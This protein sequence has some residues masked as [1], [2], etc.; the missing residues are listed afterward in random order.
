MGLSN[1]VH[2]TNVRVAR[3]PVG[4]WFRLEGSG[5][6]LERKG[7]Y[8]FTEIR[9]GLATF[10]AMA[11]IIS[12]NSTITSATGGTCVC[13]AEDMG[14]FCAT[15]VE[16]ALCTQEVKRD[17]VTATAAIAALST[18][19]MGLFANL[20]I[21]LAPGMGLNAYF[22]YTVVGVR[23]TGMVSYSTALTAVFVEGWVFLG[24]TL[25]GMR[26]WLARAL[27]KSIKLATGVGIGLY[28]ALIGLTYSAGIGL[29]QGAS[30]TPIELAGCIESE[31]D[32]VTGLCHS[33]AKMRSPT[34]WIGIFCGGILTVL[35]MMYRIKGA[36][37]I[38]ILLV[39]I[40]SWPRTTPVTYF[41]YTDLGT[42]QFD[43]FKQVVTFHPIKHT[44]SAQDWS[45]SGKGGQFGLAFITFLYVDIL[46]TTGTMYSMA[47]FAG[48]INEETQDFEGSAIAYMVDAISISIGSLLGS[49]PVTAFVESGAGIS[50][51]G[52][53]GL[54][55]CV[56]GIA[57][58]IAVFFAPIFA[59]IP[60][61]ATGCT[62]VIVGAMMAQAAADINWRYYGDAIPAFLTIAIMP[63]T[64]SIAYGLIAGITSYITLN[65]F[66]WCLEKISGG[67]IVPPNKDESDPWSWKV[68]GG[69][70]PPWVKRAARGKKDFWKADEEYAEPRVASGEAVSSSSSSVERVPLEKSREPTA[71]AMKSE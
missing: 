3:S 30:D 34:M 24:L 33:Y 5:H 37:I 63:F 9:A 22:A 18:F 61:W 45:L 26:Q 32:K 1:W 44:L 49:P 31:F 47:R 39:S 71:A 38:G 52:K 29:I 40:I 6:P 64:Y 51:G 46:D 4:K 70:L 14:D 67:R 43:F 62:L 57:F 16:Y 2:N 65:G 21:A 17:L 11:Y 69:L 27:P 58:F 56:T 68:K 48:A 20:P 53:T 15:N 36:I 13:P 42:S 59:S 28:L 60:P 25:I 55:S 66:A 19:C 23:G 41:P 12:V 8:F 50:E 7:S 54:T 10:F 35:L